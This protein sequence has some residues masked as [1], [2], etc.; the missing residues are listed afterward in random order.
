M[1][2]RNPANHAPSTDVDEATIR[3][4]V[5]LI[6]KQ[7]ERALNGVKLPGFL[8]LTRLHPLDNKLVPTRFRVGDVDGMAQQ[9]IADARAGHNVYVEGRT[10][11]EQTPRGKRGGIEQT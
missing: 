5:S 7:A 2:A 11:S 9:A 10:I 8:Q 3:K 1:D 6:H 4:F